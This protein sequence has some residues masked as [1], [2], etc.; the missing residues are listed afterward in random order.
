MP[1][2]FTVGGKVGGGGGGFMTRGCAWRSWWRAHVHPS[3]TVSRHA[4]RVYRSRGACGVAEG[5]VVQYGPPR[6]LARLP[7]HCTLVSIVCSAL[8][9]GCCCSAKT[10]G[11]CAASRRAVFA[12]VAFPPPLF[13]LFSLFIPPPR[14]VY[15]L[16]LCIDRVFLF[17]T[18]T[19]ARAPPTLTFHPWHRGRVCST[20]RCRKARGQAGRPQGG[21]HPNMQGALATWPMHPSALQKRLDANQGEPEESGATGTMG[22]PASP[23][24]PADAQHA[25]H[26]RPA[27]ATKS[28]KSVW[29]PPTQWPAAQAHV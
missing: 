9:E 26:I 20:G 8:V 15:P 7:R 18:S 4:R 1:S 23:E 25:S 2:V 21:E 11:L 5:P 29:H 13:R 3:V 24:G 10:F 17:L 16:L 19:C 12:S 28:T 6:R 14:A 27:L 22:H